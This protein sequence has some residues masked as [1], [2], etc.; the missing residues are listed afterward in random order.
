MRLCEIDEDRD[1][2]DDEDDEDAAAT[3][4]TEMES[5][6]PHKFRNDNN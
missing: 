4:T 5:F 3:T 6:L 2:G 1:D